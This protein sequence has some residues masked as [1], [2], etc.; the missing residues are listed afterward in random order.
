MHARYPKSCEYTRHTFLVIEGWHPDSCVCL[1]IGFQQ[2]SPPEKK[3]VAITTCV[4][5][6]PSKDTCTIIRTATSRC[7]SQHVAV[8]TGQKDSVGYSS[9][10]L[11]L[12][13][14]ASVATSLS[15]LGHPF[16]ALIRVH[17]VHDCIVDEVSHV[18]ARSPVHLRIY[19]GQTAAVMHIDRLC[20][21]SGSLQAPH[22]SQA[23]TRPG[24]RT[25]T[26][27]VRPV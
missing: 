4:F 9:H 20:P 14:K 6:P 26:S 24:V 16:S 2:F 25:P 23:P 10:I 18:V 5:S 19:D 7:S 11:A 13:Y 21:P 12:M 15:S 17:H 1:G 8:K 27:T 3:D 22:P